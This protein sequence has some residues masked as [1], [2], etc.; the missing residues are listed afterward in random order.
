MNFPS[1]K[2][3]AFSLAIGWIALSTAPSFAAVGSLHL[4]KINS[5][6]IRPETVI[7][8]GNQQTIYTGGITGQFNGGA[9]GFFFCFDLGHNIAVPGSYAVFQ[10]SPSA[11]LPAYLNM[12]GPFN[13]EIAASLI[14]HA[15]VASFG[16]DTNKYSALQLAIW[17]I[18]Y[19]WSAANHPDNTLGTASD[20]FSAPGLTNPTLAD[21]LAFL[22]LAQN[23]IGNP[24]YD[25]LKMMV[26]ANNSPDGHISQTLVGVGTPE[27]ETYLILGSCLL[28]VGFKLRKRTLQ[29]T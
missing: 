12:A 4:D 6:F 14:N 23:Y 29:K 18:L 7:F 25:T 9:T 27:P 17:S 13:R 1:I 8:N 19:N 3:I 11:A 26:D 21:A 10:T 20:P 16:N 5:T 24:S 15:D 2:K 22:H 28:L